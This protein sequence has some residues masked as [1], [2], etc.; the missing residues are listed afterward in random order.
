MPIS[1]EADHSVPP[2]A[3]DSVKAAA[4]I[5]NGLH[6]LAY[7]R[8]GDMIAPV[9]QAGWQPVNEVNQQAWEEIERHVELA[10]SAVRAGRRSCLYYYMVANQM[11]CHLLGQYTGQSPLLVWLH[12]RPF[13]FRWI[14]QA[15]MQRYADLFQIDTHDLAQG[16][17]RPPIYS[18]SRA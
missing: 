2:D 6:T 12:L 4:S 9:A 18:L 3:T 10:R 5:T 1:P 13:L 7:V 11:D 16:T 14:S 15:R 8:A 17:L